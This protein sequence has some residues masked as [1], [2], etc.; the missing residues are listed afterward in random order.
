M[1]VMWGCCRPGRGGCFILYHLHSNSV[2]SR[3]AAREDGHLSQTWR[4]TD[5]DPVDGPFRS[6]TV[7]STSTWTNIRDQ[8]VPGWWSAVWSVTS[9]RRV[10]AASVAE[11]AGAAEAAHTQRWHWSGGPHP[12]HSLL[13]KQTFWGHDSTNWQQPKRERGFTLSQKLLSLLDLLQEEL[14]HSFC[15]L[16]IWELQ[17]GWHSEWHVLS[18]LWS[19]N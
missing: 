8:N 16:Q 18:D 11:P 1:G 12:S 13:W 6:L 3:S 2:R 7:S 14:L 10:V 4:Q 19:T 5:K 15:I 17:Q 9:G